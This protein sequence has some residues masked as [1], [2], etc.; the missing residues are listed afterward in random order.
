ML[1]LKEIVAIVG[2]LDTLPN[3]A[4]FDPDKSFEENGIDSL[5]VMT[6]LLAV[7]ERL[8]IK[9]RDEEVDGI[10]SARDLVRTLEARR[11][12]NRR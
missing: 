8:G 6:V 5:D 1:D 3:P 4:A 9:L 11:G 2:T 7:E 10:R 12:S